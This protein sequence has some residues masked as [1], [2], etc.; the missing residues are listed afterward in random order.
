MNRVRVKFCGMTQ[1][2]DAL[3]AAALGVDAIGL[4]FYPAS[5]RCV[6]NEQAEAIINALPAFVTTVG[7]FV[8]PMPIEVHAII[9]IMPLD[10]LQFHGEES[11]EECEQYNKP[12]IKAIR[13]GPDLDLAAAIRKYANAKAILLDTYQP[14]LPGGTGKTFDWSLIPKN[15]AKPIILS[16]GLNP[17]N[18][19]QAIAQVQ[20]YAVDV[21]SGI[22][23]SP[24]KKDL[25]KMKAFMQA[26][27]SK[28]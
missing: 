10:L 2:D 13:I 22:E 15:I 5:K 27:P 4:I 21:A 16:G 12:Y 7:V 23:I 25:N 9:D 18:V 20:P 11:P 17:E 26:I 1:V 24:G 14:D 6:I 3:A 28:S 19:A 8:D